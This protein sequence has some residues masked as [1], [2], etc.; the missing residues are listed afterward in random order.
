MPRRSFK[1][2]TFRRRKY[3]TKGRKAAAIRKARMRS[4]RR[5]QTYLM[6][7]IIAK[8]TIAKLKYATQ[9]SITPAAGGIDYHKFRC[10]DLYDPDFTSTGHQPF[11]FDQLMSQYNHFTVIG[12]KIHCKFS[13]GTNPYVAAL[14]THAGNTWAAS[15]ATELKEIQRCNYRFVAQTAGER[16]QNIVLKRKFSAKK[17]FDKKGIVGDSLYRGTS[18]SSPS[19]Q[20]YY[21]VA[22]GAN[23]GSTTIGTII[24]DVMIT[25]IGVFTEPVQYGGS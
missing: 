4:Y 16:P 25:F 13:G 10:N 1:K 11:G 2:R 18:T 17:F 24:V 14:S 5:N 9:V 23:D 15:N 8:S 12:S 20:A 19:E 7:G 6:K 22:V 21:Y 3:S